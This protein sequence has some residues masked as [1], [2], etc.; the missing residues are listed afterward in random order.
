MVRRQDL[1]SKN[2]SENILV[3]N[4]QFSLKTRNKASLKTRKT[5]AFEIRNLTFTRLHKWLG[6]EEHAACRLK[7]YLA[8]RHC[9]NSPHLKNGVVKLAHFI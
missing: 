5:K 2:I 1:P 7:W 9:L 8:S 3:H 6:T 4:H